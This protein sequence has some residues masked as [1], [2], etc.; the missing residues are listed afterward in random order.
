MKNKLLLSSALISG[1]AFAGSALAETK[2][3]GSMDISLG[4]RSSDRAIDSSS[5]F[6]SETQLNIS[7]SGTLNNGMGYAAGFSMESDSSSGAAGSGLDGFENAYI[8][9]MP[10]KGTMLHFGSDH[11]PPLDGT[12]TPKVSIAADTLVGAGTGG[13]KAND[14]TTNVS[15]RDGT[16]I[17]V[18]EKQGVGLLQDVGTFGKVGIYYAPNMGVD[19]NDAGNDT[20]NSTESTNSATSISFRGNLGVEGLSVLAG[21][22]KLKKEAGDVQ[23]LKSRNLGIAYNFGKVSVG[24]SQIKTDDDESDTDLTT[25]EVGITFAASDNLSFGISR[26]DTEDSTA[27][28]ADEEIT[29]VQVGYNLGAVS[30]SLN[31]AQIDN[32]GNI[33]GS[34]DEFTLLRI[35]TKF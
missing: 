27:G 9:F 2:I 10:V 14:T 5:G 20:V 18:V 11:F 7:N 8:N 26:H 30:V 34:D 22:E 28:T 29:M 32:I 13:T 35:G 17:D 12:V 15:Y 1:L 31:Y 3:T 23:D 25:K 4:S 24:V 16:H 33:S 6:G 19:G 21:Q